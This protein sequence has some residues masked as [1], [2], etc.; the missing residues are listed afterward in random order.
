MEL[1]Q[2]ESGTTDCMWHRERAVANEY[3]GNMG[4]GEG[5]TRLGSGLTAPLITLEA[6]A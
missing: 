6:S 1:V 5:C 3:R 2:F 4:D